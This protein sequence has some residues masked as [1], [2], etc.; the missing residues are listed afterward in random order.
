[1]PDF[2]GLQVGDYLDLPS[3]NDGSA[4]YVWSDAYKNLRVVIAGFNTYKNMGGTE[5][6]KN[7][8][9]FVFDNCPLTKQMNSGD[10]NAGGYASSSLKTYI[11]GGFKDGLISVLGRDY[12][13]MVGRYI[14]TKSSY[15]ELRSSIFIPTELEVYGMQIQGD[16]ISAGTKYPSPVQLP[17]YRDSYKH[18]VKRYNGSRQWWW[19]CTP[20]SGSSSYFCSV[21]GYGYAS[22]SNASSAGGLAPAF[23]VA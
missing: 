11:E 3:L 14:S 5:N 6:E 10:T 19:S 12:M 18:R 17:I 8:I 9:V 15:S 16:E 2:S 22:N 1:V 4:N 23:C 7:H 21:H 13:Y 20:F